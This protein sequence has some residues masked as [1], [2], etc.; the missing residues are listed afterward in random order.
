MEGSASTPDRATAKH[1]PASRCRRVLFLF[2]WA[3]VL[4]P[5]GALPL[6]AHHFD[7]PGVLL[8]YYRAKEA[9]YATLFRSE[10][11]RVLDTKLSV[12]YDLH[13]D[14]VQG[15]SAADAERDRALSSVL[16]QRYAG[17][18]IH[19]LIPIGNSAVEFVRVHGRELFPEASVVYLALR[20]GS[21]PSSPPLLQGTGVILQFEAEAT[22]E[23][24]L[25]QNPGTRRVMVVAGTSPEERL[26]IRSVRDEFRRFEGAVEFQYVSD[27]TLAALM[28]RLSK[29]P[30]NSLV[31]LLSFAQDSAGEQFFGER[32]VPT[33]SL[34]ATRPMYTVLSTA[35]GA[36]AVG[37]QVHDL[38]AVGK[39]VGELA[40]RVLTGTRASDIPVQEGT[41]QR[42]MFDWQQMR[43]WG[44]LQTQLPPGTLVLSRELSL[45]DRHKWWIIAALALLLFQAAL[46]SGLLAEWIRKRRAESRLAAELQHEQLVSDLAETFMNLPAELVSESIERGFERVAQLYGLDRI[47]LFEFSEDRAAMKLRY[48]HRNPE[49]SAPPLDLPADQF[50]WIVKNVLQRRPSH[51]TSLDELPAEAASTRASLQTLGVRSYAVF[52]IQSEAGV[53]GAISFAS[54]TRE[55][56]WT[57]DL[58][59]ELQTVA[60][61]FSN[62]LERKR[63]EDA[64]RT[65]EELKSKIVDSLI[66]H[67]AVID[68]K[69]KIVAVN[70]RWRD[71]W[72]E[73]GGPQ[74]SSMGVGANYLDIC[75]QGSLAGIPE[76]DRALAGILSVLEGKA[77]LFEM[78]Y[79][80]P[81][82]EQHR[83]FIMVVAPLLEPNH[84]AVIR[85]RDITFSKQAAIRLRESEERFRVL[86]DSAPVMIWT[87]G[88]EMRRTHFN[89][90]WLE[91]AAGPV[92][93]ELGEGWTGRVHPDDLDRVLRIHNDS[94]AARRPF[95]LRYRLRRGDGKYRWILENGVPRKLLDGTYAGYIGGCVDVT[96]QKEAEETRARVSGLLITAQEQER[97]SIARELHDHINQ[98]LALLAIE[99]QEFEH[100][101]AGLLP[102]KRHDLQELWE[103]TTE[104]SH[105]VQ[106]LSHQLHSSQL[107]HLGLISAVRG[108]CQE[109]TKT[110]G[111][112]AECSCHGTPVKVEENVS[113]ALFRIVQEALRNVAKYGRARNVKV[114]MAWKPGELFL[115]ISDD[116]VGF[117][118]EAVSGAGLGL[119]S[120]KE[121]MR[122]V[123][124]EFA[125]RSAPGAGTRIEARVPLVQ[126][127]AVAAQAN[128]PVLVERRKRARA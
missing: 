63:A 114:E 37:G 51:A 79:E 1:M 21:T 97:A 69:G 56:H 89:R 34:A 40:V 65:S 101:V 116:G 13:V 47:S 67:L 102:D 96:E 78:E 28:A 111:V 118:P 26:E 120:M 73:N 86:A 94:A 55:I 61:I 77:D 71:F 112:E 7:R 75:R 5:P 119:I 108:L 84:G 46:I 103:L 105:D 53:H 43:R 110:A 70:K 10:I 15:W 107:Q 93:E 27:I 24:A 32:L 123:G 9:P 52:P 23:L 11:A 127:K 20:Y 60:D 106:A 2:F 87:S 59:L 19:L 98:R 125:A 30:P 88:T 99:I 4:L 17:S 38:N 121:R 18:N 82:P 95:Q 12:P 85:H 16:R 100:S 31:L 68:G 115:T 8:L 42:P 117:D 80:C 25:R 54:V 44:I 58:L 39:A 126:R 90:A 76:A 49:A 50:A 36:G 57:P 124:G 104:I 74:A 91:F 92:D 45:W 35:V 66:S 72:V 81:T 29:L 33:L 6:Q 62:A 128:L 83:W 64:L 109:F 41:F 113:L 22:L 48:L 122:L 3:A 14:T